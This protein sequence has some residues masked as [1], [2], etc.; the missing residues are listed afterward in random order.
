MKKLDCFAIWSL[1]V[2]MNSNK[3]VLCIGLLIRWTLTI[4]WCF[5]KHKVRY[6]EAPNKIKLWTQ[7]L[8][9]ISKV[10]FSTSEQKLIV[11]IC[12]VRIVTTDRRTDGPPRLSWSSRSCICLA[13]AS[14]DSI[15][16]DLESGHFSSYQVLSRDHRTSHRTVH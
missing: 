14:R 16:E 5:K 15:R 12:L 7:P 9:P 10:L 6:K 11:N 3:G 13:V 1:S 8:R 4:V 2:L